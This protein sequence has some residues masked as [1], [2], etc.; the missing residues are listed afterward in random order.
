M[1]FK[2]KATIQEL[3]KHI[4]KG[5]SLSI[6]KGYVAVDK[7]GV[8]KL[9]DT[10]YATLPID[11]LEARNYLKKI[12]K[13]FNSTKNPTDE[14]KGIYHYLNALEIELGS[15]VGLASYVV[16]N[17]KDIEKII[18]K[19]YDSIPEEITEAETLSNE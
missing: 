10:I 15:G 9:I 7:R 12:Q 1:E 14:T 5:Y 13:P 4:E 6:F 3:E 8:E 19:I 17:I 18:D 11:V 16:L 2:T